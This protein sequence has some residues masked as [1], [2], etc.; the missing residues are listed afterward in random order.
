MTISSYLVRV[1]ID[2]V[3]AKAAKAT[4]IGYSAN[5]NE[6]DAIIGYVSTIC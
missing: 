5:F 1:V 2:W 6:V 3:I 4:N